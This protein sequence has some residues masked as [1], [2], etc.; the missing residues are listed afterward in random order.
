M[1]NTGLN[2]IAET[3]TKEI[4][5]I[6]HPSLKIAGLQFHPESILTTSGLQILRNWFNAINCR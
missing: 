1:E 6:A 3:A 2:V 5:A 4:M